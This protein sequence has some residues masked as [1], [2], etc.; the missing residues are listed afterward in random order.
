MREPIA[1]L[2]GLSH[3]ANVVSPPRNRANGNRRPKSLERNGQRPTRLLQSD[4]L[5]KGVSYIMPCLPSTIT[6]LKLREV[7]FRNRL[8]CHGIQIRITHL[9]LDLRIDHENGT[10]R[11]PL[12]LYD[13]LHDR[14]RQFRIP[15]HLKTL[16]LSLSHGGLVRESRRYDTT[17]GGDR[18][19]T[20]TTR[21]R[22]SQSI[23]TARL[24]QPSSSQISR[25]EK[26]DNKVSTK[27]KNFDLIRTCTF[28]APH[29]PRPTQL[30]L[31]YIAA[32]H[33]RTLRHL[34]S[35]SVVFKVE[36]NDVFGWDIGEELRDA[37]S[38]FEA[39]C[40]AKDLCFYWPG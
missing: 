39:L 16:R 23:S 1:F 15:K 38:G 18:I 30:T 26:N 6:S 37:S 12:Q 28:P 27:K 19:C 17:R 10:L 29:I 33:Q 11:N 13:A 2:P 32:T 35:H 36:G 14:R 24:E 20:S 9:D 40:S 25:S 22:T 4:I 5:A 3:V 8:Y 31:L 34:E 7:P 21:S